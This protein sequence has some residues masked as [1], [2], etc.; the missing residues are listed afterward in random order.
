MGS[1]AVL[2]RWRLGWDAGQLGLFPSMW[3]HLSLPMSSFNVVFPEGELDLLYGGSSF[4]KMQ[5]MEA[6]RPIKL[7]PELV[8]CQFCHLLSVTS[9][10]SEGGVSVD[11]GVWVPP[12]P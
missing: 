4:P 2:T 7:R 10:F 9:S 8:Q 1:L 3:S 5:K 11:G 6:A 12:R